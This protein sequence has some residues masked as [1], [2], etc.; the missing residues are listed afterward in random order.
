MA[1][2]YRARDLARQRAVAVK[3]LDSRLAEDA[4]YVAQ[5]R[6]E[7]RRAAR[8]SHP[9]IVPLYDVGE[10]VIGERRVLYLVMPL[11]RRSLSQ[12]LRRDGALPY[13]E[14]IRLALEVAAGLEAAHAAGLIH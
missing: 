7:A 1:E 9:R 2:V 6:D 10:G 8:L 14:A 5:F 4:T 3:V 12:R 13:L 11:L